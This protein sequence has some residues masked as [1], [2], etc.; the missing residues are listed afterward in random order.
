[1]DTVKIH[2][3]AHGQRVW[4]PTFREE[5]TVFHT[6]TLTAT[7][8]SYA[9]AQVEWP[10]GMVWPLTAIVAADLIEMGPDLPR[11]PRR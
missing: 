8:G 1:M 2:G 11:A 7:G 9:L 4:H 3:L 5:G 10:D 6:R